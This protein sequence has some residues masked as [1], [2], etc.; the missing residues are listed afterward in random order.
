MTGDSCH[1]SMDSVSVNSGA[2]EL[3]SSAVS[4]SISWIDEFLRDVVSV[5]MDRIG[6]RRG[7]LGESGG[8]SGCV[9]CSVGRCERSWIGLSMKEFG[10]VDC[11]SVDLAEFGPMSIMGDSSCP[12]CP[13]CPNNKIGGNSRFR[14]DG[15]LTG[16]IDFLCS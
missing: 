13:R 16:S 9:E 1:D 12:C 14:G 11:V 3:Y 2:S 8:G 15:D 7:D 6:G 10:W 5:A 4:Y